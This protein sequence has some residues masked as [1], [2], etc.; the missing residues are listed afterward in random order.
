[1]QIQMYL[2]EM[3]NCFFCVADSD[4]NNSKKVDIL[5]IAF[6]HEFVSNLLDN[7]LLKFWKNKV[8]PLLYQSVVNTNTTKD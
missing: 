7:N 2:T 4:F 1:M 5:S 6:N 8:Y 3:K